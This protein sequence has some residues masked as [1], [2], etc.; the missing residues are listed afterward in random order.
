MGGGGVLILCT[1][2]PSTKGNEGTC[3]FR[4]LRDFNFVVMLNF[5]SPWVENDLCVLFTYEGS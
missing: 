1:L 2:R 3:A 5:V 4:C